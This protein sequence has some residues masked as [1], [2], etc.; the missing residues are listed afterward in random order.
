VLRDLLR[1][2]GLNVEET[3]SIVATTRNDLVPFL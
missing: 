3:R 2:S 1:L